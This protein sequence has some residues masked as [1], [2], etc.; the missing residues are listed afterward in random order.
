MDASEIDDI[1]GAWDYTSLPANVRI[2]AGCF[3]ERKFS[4]SRFRSTQDSGFVLGDR[5]RVYTWSMFNVEPA[6]CIEVGDD[7]TLVGAV[8]MCAQQILIGRRVIVSYNVTIADCDF[9]PH[10]P[11]ERKKDAI[12]NA[13]FGDRSNRPPL[14]TRP[15]VIKDN[16]WIGIGA[17]ILKGVTI[18]AGARVGAGA[19]I[20][21]D[22]PPG[23]SVFGNP[24]QAIASAEGDLLV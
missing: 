21:H 14:I 2:G 12:A 17:I 8:F 10:D 3:L 19:V 7:S 9:H 15:V 22:V 1:T 4:F 5:V 23:A 13:P 20:T 24:A 11:E 6:G 16:A 18:G